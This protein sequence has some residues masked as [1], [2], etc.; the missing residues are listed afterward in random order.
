MVN[1]KQG[2]LIVIEGIECAGKDSCLDARRASLDNDA[3]NFVFTRELGGTYVS[4]QIREILLKHAN[5][6]CAE[7]EICLAHASRL[8]HVKDLISPALDLGK[9][10]VSNRFDASTYAYQG[11]KG[12]TD[13]MLSMCVPMH[14]GEPLLPT[15]TIFLDLPIE[16]SMARKE[17]RNAVNNIKDDA[18]EQRA[19]AF[20][21]L[22]RKRYLEHAILSGGRTIVLSADNTPAK[23][24][25]VFD[26]AFNYV[27]AG[28][29][30]TFF[31]HPA[32][33]YDAELTRIIRNLEVTL[34]D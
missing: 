4:E 25:E 30:P 22:V 14:N 12:A 18:I 8:Q 5:E 1:T 26:L 19:H 29:D 20:F 9:I 21:N 15:A 16:V 34:E 10:V 6:M 24:Q 3:T 28:R 31:C 11:A 33:K 23:V 2:L 7:T 13:H 32:R 17:N 27:V